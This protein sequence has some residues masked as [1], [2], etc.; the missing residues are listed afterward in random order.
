MNPILHFSQAKEQAI[1]D[2]SGHVM[3]DIE[4]LGVVEKSH[5]LSIGYCQ[6]DPFKGP[7]TTATGAKFNPRQLGL[8][9]SNQHRR[10]GVST[11]EWW[12]KADEDAM[13]EAFFPAVQYDILDALMVLVSDLS[14]LPY[15][16]YTIWANGVK[17][18]ITIL[19]DA[20]KQLNIAIP[21]SFRQVADVR[22]LTALV[23]RD[24]VQNEATIAAKSNSVETGYT[25][26]AHKAIDD[27]LW[28]AHFI[29]QAIKYLK[30]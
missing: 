8:G 23:D 9:L 7:L 17:F 24:F 21:W 16:G 11:L 28:Q 27:A 30:G 19:E 26:L 29:A 2:N 5:I 22:S 12:F 4:T 13:D 20:F 14:L 25:N 10:L 1:V 15:H 3:I 6:F 18:D